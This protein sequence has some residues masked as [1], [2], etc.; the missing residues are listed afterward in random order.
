MGIDNAKSSSL[1]QLSTTQTELCFPALFSSKTCTRNAPFFAFKNSVGNWGIVQGCCN[2]W[3]CPR[4]GQ[5][6]AREEYGRIVEGC[7]TIADNH[8][9][10]F[11]TLT[12]KGKDM[13]LREA[14]EHYGKWTNRVLTALRT[15]GKRE[16]QAWY[17]VQV[18][19]RQ[20]RAH[21]HSHLLTTF[22]APDLYLGHVFKWAH[23]AQGRRYSERQIA[24]RSD[25]LEDIVTGA[26]LGREYDIS[27]VATVEGAARYVAKYLFKPTIFSTEWPKGWKRVRYSQSF[28]KLPPRQGE[29]FILLSAHDWYE[30][31]TIAETV[32]A[33]DQHSY[34][35]ARQALANYPVKVV[36]RTKVDSMSRT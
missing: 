19:E 5:I 15:R 7:R 26:G 27:R 22:T 30:L 28:P 2:S 25:W 33:S 13:P 11:I 21:P 24:L 18:T 1:D 20:K 12:C 36:N 17:Y 23:N 14:E 9:L 6:R 32:S 29:A 8:A 4:C 34:N 31:A 10:Y 35:V 16:D 3:T